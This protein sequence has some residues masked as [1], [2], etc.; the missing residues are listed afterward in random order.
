MEPYS[1]LASKLVD[2]HVSSAGSFSWRDTGKLAALELTP[3]SHHAPGFQEP[4]KS[5]DISPQCLV[6]SQ[7]C[8]E[9]LWTTYGASRSQQGHWQPGQHP[10]N[11]LKNQYIPTKRGQEP[12]VGFKV[13]DEPRVCREMNLG[14]KQAPGAVSLHPLTL[15]CF[16]VLPPS[17]P[18]LLPWSTAPNRNL[19]GA[20]CILTDFSLRRGNL[21]SIP[22]PDF[23]L[24]HGSSTAL[25]C[26]LLRDEAGKIFLAEIT[27][28]KINLWRGWKA[29]SIQINQ[30]MSN[31]FA[32]CGSS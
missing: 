6:A 5:T 30:C 19:P 31:T 8:R 18:A 26:D 15:S 4:G 24:T 11:G 10:S 22:L 27:N 12:P 20:V 23:L 7:M 14:G 17:C 28:L 1:S 13:A 3:W 29:M 25:C 32:S 21:F 9:G 16:T 2:L